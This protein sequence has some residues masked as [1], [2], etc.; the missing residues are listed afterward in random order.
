MNSAMPEPPRPPQEPASSGSPVVKNTPIGLNSVAI[1]LSLASLAFSV[2]A[3]NRPAPPMDMAAYEA[4][5]Q[6][7]YGQ[8]QSSDEVCPPT[9][10]PEGEKS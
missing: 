3:L 4:E 8:M 5:L 7:A 10:M 6:K 2:Y 1:V 9:V